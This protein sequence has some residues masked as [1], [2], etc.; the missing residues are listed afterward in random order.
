MNYI[1][2][3]G[4]VP[5]VIGC[6]L[7]N[8]HGGFVWGEVVAC[9]RWCKQRYCGKRC[10]GFWDR[11]VYTIGGYVAR[12]CLFVG[13]ILGKIGGLYEVMCGINFPP[14]D[15]PSGEL[16]IKTANGCRVFFGGIFKVCISWDNYQWMHSTMTFGSKQHKVR[17][18]VLKAKAT[19][20]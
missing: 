16:S 12:C 4:V 15:T 20:L 10:K 9:Y 13:S 14:I 19:W 5:W 17:Y 8:L 3:W 1:R 11:C 7:A 2:I 6:A 18:A